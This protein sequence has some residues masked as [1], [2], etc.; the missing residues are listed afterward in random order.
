MEI[1][2]VIFAIKIREKYIPGQTFVIRGTESIPS[3]DRV[4]FTLPLEFF[5]KLQKKCFEKIKQNKSLQKTN[6]FL[7]SIGINEHV[8]TL[9]SLHI[10]V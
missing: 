10:F 1:N 9:F 8:N 6:Y 7:F 5:R 4:S 3:F 2:L